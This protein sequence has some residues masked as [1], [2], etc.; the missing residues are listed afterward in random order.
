MRSKYGNDAFIEQ[1][2]INH[3]AF[4]KARVG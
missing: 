3:E 1:N 2:S 4:E